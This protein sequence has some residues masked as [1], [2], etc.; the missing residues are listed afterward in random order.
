MTD[1][2]ENMS[3]ENLLEIIYRQNEEINNLAGALETFEKKF[4]EAQQ[5][6]DIGYW[7]WDIHNNI[8][9]WSEHAYKIHDIEPDTK[10]NYEVLAT[11]IHP[12]DREDHYNLT[13]S[14]IKN[15]GGLPFEYRIVTRNGDIK[16]IRAFGKVE[17][18]DAGE[19]AKFIGA[20]QDVTEKTILQNKLQNA[21]T[22]ALEGFLPICSYCKAIRN[23]S[24]EW[25]SLEK[26][27]S[28]RSMAKLT[29]GICPECAKNI[30]KDIDSD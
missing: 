9:T 6:A 23:E 24:N 25:D 3:R 19:P 30:Y 20:L 2:Y 18:D 8:A 16:Y 7:E 13:Q 12:H 22:K 10:V 17:C 1:N 11:K 28:Q 4:N 5:I 29:H 26:Y 21:L 14:W 27:I 15:R